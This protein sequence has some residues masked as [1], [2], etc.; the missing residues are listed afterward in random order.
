MFENRVPGRISGTKIKS[1]GMRW[2]GHI[3]RMDEKTK[4]YRLLTGKPDGKR[5][6]ERQEVGG[7]IA[8]RGI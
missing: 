3:A 7:W 2:A 8:L 1:R 5:S 6:L 4:A